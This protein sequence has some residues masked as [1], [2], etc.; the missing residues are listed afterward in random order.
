MKWPLELATH[1]QLREVIKKEVSLQNYHRHRPCCLCS[2]SIDEVPIRVYKN[3]EARGIPFPKFQP[4]GVYSTLWEADDWATRGGLE[5]INWSRA[6][7]Y[8]YYKDFDLEGCVAPGAANC[9]SNPNN[10]WEGPAYQQL[11]AN[12]ARRYKWVRM[13]HL[14]YDYCTDKSRYPVTPPECMAGI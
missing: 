11:D 6:P 2:F 13:N 4:M 3:N 7:F 9:A 8:A 5:K 14:I 12:Q 10:W 1:A